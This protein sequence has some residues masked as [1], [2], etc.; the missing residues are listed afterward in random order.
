MPARH[1]VRAA[2]TLAEGRRRTPAA[3]PIREGGMKKRAVALIVGALLVLTTV[4]VAT[5]GSTGYEGQP[6][7][8][9]NGQG[10]YEGRAGNQ[11]G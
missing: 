7:N 5:A 3:L 8:Q 9:G 4:S 2:A 1:T 6:G 11:G 10:G